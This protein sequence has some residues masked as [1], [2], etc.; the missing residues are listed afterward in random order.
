MGAVNYPARAAGVS[1]MCTA[2]DARRLC[3][4]MV[5]VHVETIDC[6]VD[7]AAAADAASSDPEEEG[8]EEEVRS[9]AK[10]MWAV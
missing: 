9:T 7:G 4:A 1:R 6:G 8:D 2:T 5:T 10:A 3:P